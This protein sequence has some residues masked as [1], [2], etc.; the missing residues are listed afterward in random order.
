MSPSHLHSLHEFYIL[1]NSGSFMWVKR[2]LFTVLALKCIKF[3]FQ[4]LNW[5][6]KNCLESDLWKIW[7]LELAPV[8]FLNHL[9]QEQYTLWNRSPAPE[10]RD[11]SASASP[12]A[13]PKDPPGPI[14]ASLSWIEKEGRDGV[15]EQEKRR[16]GLRDISVHLFL[17][18]F[19]SSCKEIQVSMSV[20]T[21]PFLS[22]SPRCLLSP[23]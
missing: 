10:W 1:P 2:A 19:H 22:R 9:R 20:R 11:C 17:N 8:L 21:P 13:K 6:F 4:M 12:S 15:R 18:W 7:N 16:E 14:D 5:N 3:S 23:S